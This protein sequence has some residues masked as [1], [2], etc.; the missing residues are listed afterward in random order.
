MI[1]AE[2]SYYAPVAL[3]EAVS[4]LQQQ[5]GAKILAGGQSLIPAMR[6]RLATPEVLIDIN[7]IAGLDYLKETNGYLAIGALTREATIDASDL[8]H[9]KYP[10]LADTAAVIAD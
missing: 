1:P 8:V 10:M 9:Q 3:G 5:P 2:F 7:R 6:L 4:L